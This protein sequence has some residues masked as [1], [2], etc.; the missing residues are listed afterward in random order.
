MLRGKAEIVIIN[1]D[2]VVLFAL[3]STLDSEYMI[4]CFSNADEA[5]NSLELIKPSLILL[6]IIIQN[7]RNLEVIKQLK[8]NTATCEIP[9]IMITP[10]DDSIDLEELCFKLGADDCISKPLKST[11]LLARVQ[12]HIRNRELSKMAYIDALTELYNRR[13]FNEFLNDECNRSIQLNTFLSLL[14][15]D[16]D[17][18]KKYNDNYGNHCGDDVIKMVGLAINNAMKRSAA[19][20]ARYG[21]EEFAVILSD[22][23]ENEAAKLAKK[24][25]HT[26][27]E[28]KIKHE[29]SDVSNTKYVTVSIGGATA[30]A[31]SMGNMLVSRAD[32]MLYKAKE[33]G[34]DQFC[35]I[36]IVNINS[37]PI[38]HIRSNM[39]DALINKKE[40]SNMLQIN[41]KNTINLL[42]EKIS[43]QITTRIRLRDTLAKTRDPLDYQKYEEDLEKCETVIID[44]SLQLAELSVQYPEIE[45][46]SCLTSDIIDICIKNAN[47]VS[48]DG[49]NAIRNELLN[50]SKEMTNNEDKDISQKLEA[51]VSTKGSLELTIPII[52]MILN[53][54]SSVSV[55]T[56]LKLKKVIISLFQK[57]KGTSA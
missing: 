37:L 20:V 16:I 27:R 12:T 10:K 34:R 1:S 43:K 25:N 45:I 2:E 49:F 55:D 50:L 19:K 8:A 18:F 44:F 56:K 52:P 42:Q 15:I 46:D 48:N 29:Y 23:D 24:I 53:Y 14:I 21:G 35:I 3:R 31:I 22:A 54:K 5:I 32:E 38:N 39:A 17:C 26:I 9:V 47:K 36:S 6:D 4:H 57:I 11:V 30:Q 33:N 41:V 28:L 40:K 51:E 13:S 7:V